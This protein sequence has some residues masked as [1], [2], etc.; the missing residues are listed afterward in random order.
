MADGGE[1]GCTVTGGIGGGG[2]SAIGGGAGTSAIGGGAGTET[3]AITGAEAAVGA[4]RACGVGTF[5]TALA[6]SVLG[7]PLT[8]ASGLPASRIAIICGALRVG[9]D[10]TFLTMAAK[11]SPGLTGP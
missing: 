8:N 10:G 4:P 6:R 5:R 11:V 7:L 1:I 9:D 3:A 2:A